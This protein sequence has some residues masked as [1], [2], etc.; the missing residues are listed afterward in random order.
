MAVITKQELEDAAVDAQTIEDVVNGSETFGDNGVVVS[1]LG[2]Q[3]RTLK[4]A[5]TDMG[6]NAPVAYASGV[7]VSDPTYTVVVGDTVYAP[8]PDLL[9]FTTQA[10][11]TPA[12]W[13]ALSLYATYATVAELK[14]SGAPS[15]G[16]GAVWLAGGYFYEEVAASGDITTIGGVHLRVTPIAGVYP[17]LA[18]GVA[19]DGSTDD[20]AAYQAI[21]ASLP[22]GATLRCVGGGT[23][24]LSDEVIWPQDNLTIVCDN[25]A[26]F[27][28]AD[29]VSFLDRYFYFTGDYGTLS[30]GKFDQNVNGQSLTGVTGTDGRREGIYVTGDYWRITGCVMEGSHDEAYGTTMRI[31]GTYCVVENITTYRT[32]RNAFRDWGDYNTYRNIRMLD[33]LAGPSDVC[34]AWSKDYAPG[35][36]AFNLTTLDNI[37]VQS[38]TTYNFEGILF[39]HDGVQGACAR[40]RNV[41]IDCPNSTGPDIMKF[42][43]VY[44][45]EMHNVRL[46]PHANVDANQSA[47]LRIQTAVSRLHMHDCV[48]AGGVNFDADRDCLFTIS[49]NSVLGNETV[50][51]NLIEG[52]RGTFVAHDGVEFRKTSGNFLYLDNADADAAYGSKITFGRCGYHGY[53]ATRLVGLPSFANTK[54]RLVA[55]NISAAE[56]LYQDNVRTLADGSWLTSSDQTD[57]ACQQRGQRRFVAFRSDIPPRPAEG[58]QRGDIIDDR[59]NY[60]YSQGII[61]C[62]SPGASCRT[63]WA[64]GESV[65]IGTW[66]YANGN[67]YAAASAGTT[68]ATAPSGTGTGI[69]DGAVTW[70]YIDALAVWSGKFGATVPESSAA[71]ISGAGSLI[72]TFDKFRGK[73]VWNTD[74]N[75][76][77]IASGPNPTDPWYYV[78]GSGTV[79]PA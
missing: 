26:T 17:D 77:L 31:A 78:D 46:K 33:C 64:T 15:R 3:I 8:R 72:N 60:D 9:P 53:G 57:A 75:K 36:S 40:V 52:F 73:Q 63:A 50:C 29:N 69:S 76:L 18:Y 79:T 58:W 5:V 2:Q 27:K 68:G 11:F 71:N 24:V 62:V 61:R 34:H 10:S 65:S 43:Y 41:W 4:R 13:F 12:Y 16:T 22:N 59:S 54:R 42:V 38:D 56:P 55:G 47:S 37:V 21:A 28:V 25:G 39:D 19:A 1:R 7:L 6:F 48:I 67:V 74:T 45:V 30:G 66:R 35:G 51:V 70:D 20:T 49:G 23:R 14:A 44:R 32:G